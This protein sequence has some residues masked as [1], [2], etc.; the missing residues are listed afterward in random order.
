MVNWLIISD[1]IVE[2]NESKVEKL[3]NNGSLS[4]AKLEPLNIRA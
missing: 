3:V 4:G 1:P 2:P